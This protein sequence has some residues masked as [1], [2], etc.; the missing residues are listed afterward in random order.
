MDNKIN[1]V[2]FEK[3]SQH[4]LKAVRGVGDKTLQRLTEE[5][6]IE[7][8]EALASADPMKVNVPNIRAMIESAQ[9]LVKSQ[10]TNDTE[11]SP[12]L[13]LVE[14]DVRYMLE[15]HTWFELKVSLPPS[16]GQKLKQA[17]IQD[18]CLE[19]DNRVSLLCS[20]QEN[21]EFCSMTY[22]PQYLFFFN[23]KL[24]KLE[25]TIKP[26]DLAKLPN[27][28]TLENTLIEVNHMYE[29]LRASRF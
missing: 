24:P 8:V 4:V 9:A 5:Y 12:P 28:K 29:S 21:D 14:T 2:F 7:T 1:S 22:S 23:M 27:L 13:E 16:T 25:V 26:T 20:W 11:T 6:K 19:P 15:E 3:M 18:L 17:I 10:D